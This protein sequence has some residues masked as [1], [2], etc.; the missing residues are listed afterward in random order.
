MF[1]I[2]RLLLYSSLW[3][4]GLTACGQHTPFTPLPPSPSSGL[5]AA[6]ADPPLLKPPLA[7]SAPPPSLPPSLP[8]SPPSS[9]PPPAYFNHLISLVTTEALPLKALLMEAARQ[10]QA[11]VAIHP[12]IQG[13]LFYQ[14][15]RRPFKAIV[16]DICEMT[17][18]RAR[19]QGH[20]LHIEPDSLYWQTYS[21]ASLSLVRENKSRTSISTDIFTGTDNKG[22]ALDNGSTSLLSANTTANFW[23]ELKSNLKHLLKANYEEEDGE[24]A[25]FSFHRLGGTLTIFATQKQHRAVRSFLRSLLRNTQT[26]VLIEAKI[27]EVLLKD[28]FKSGVHWHSFLEGLK[29]A[30]TIG[31]IAVSTLQKEASLPARNVFSLGYSTPNLG[32]FVSLL[33]HYGVV[34]TLSSPRLTVLNNQSAIM[35]V[36]TNQVFFR[37]DYSRETQSIHHARDIERATSHVQTIPIGLVMSVHPA[38]NLENGTITLNLRPTISRV[39]AEKEDP[40]VAI[41][42]RQEKVSTVPEVQVREFDSVLQVSSGETV[43][44]GGLIEERTD[45]ETTHV[46]FFSELPLVGPALFEGKTDRTQRSELIIFLRATLQP[47]SDPFTVADLHLPVIEAW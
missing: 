43:V 27:V 13:S 11:N 45:K 35:K 6:Q 36:A 5:K 29:L 30:T 20:T 15:H 25:S 7:V 23:E 24:E 19:L 17:G 18:L 32:A 21:L 46:P 22:L 41:L 31:D 37:I 42:S 47:A 44:M 38:A 28:E 16:D 39:V 1:T 3:A 14:A 34:R 26:Q 10:A 12:N 4:L 33:S 9:P 40:A 2:S 8:L